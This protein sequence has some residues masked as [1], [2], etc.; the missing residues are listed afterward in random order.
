VGSVQALLRHARHIHLVDPYFDA[1][2]GGDWR[3]PLRLLIQQAQQERESDESICFVVHLSIDRE[4][5]G[6]GVIQSPSNEKAKGQTI[7]DDLRGALGGVLTKPSS[8]KARIWS[9]RGGYRGT[10]RLH[11]RYILTEAGGVMFGVGLDA[12]R[13]SDMVALLSRPQWERCREVY[14]EN[15]CTFRLVAEETFNGT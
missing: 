14:H 2:V 9:Q 1:A 11:N 6:S 7:L 4:F 15:D 10:E 3:E 5:N 13:G 8:L 12:G